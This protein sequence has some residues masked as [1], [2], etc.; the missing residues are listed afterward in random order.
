MTIKSPKGLVI[1]GFAAGILVAGASAIAVASVSSWGAGGSRIAFLV[2]KPTGSVQPSGAAGYRI[3]PDPGFPIQSPGL[4]RPEPTATP[5]PAYKGPPWA[6]FLGQSSTDPRIHVVS[7]VGLEGLALA[8]GSGADR[9]QLPKPATQLPLVSTS[10]TRAYYLDG[11]SDLRYLM[12][13]GKSGLARHIPGTAT[14]RAV[15]AV[16]PDDQQIAVST[17]DYGTEPPALRFFIEGMDGSHHLDLFSSRTE[18]LWPIGWHAG[19]VVMAAGEA[20]P[21]TNNHVGDGYQYCDQTLGPCTSDNPY[22]ATHGYRLIDARNGAQVGTMASGVCTAIGLMTPS[23]TLC[24]EG[25]PPGGLITPTSVCRDELTFCLRQVDWSGAITDWTTE[26]VT[27][28][29]VLAGDGTGVAACCNVNAINLYPPRRI[30][31]TARQVGPAAWPL[32]FLDRS[33]L[34]YRSFGA[35]YAHMRDLD[36]GHDVTI[37]A[38]GVPVAN[39]PGAF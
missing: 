18:Y 11:N 22:S 5:G 33:T 3:V 10:S 7:I 38:P 16:S 20:Y 19:N 23:G 34:V 30:G 26:A 12:P 14:V 8:S 36:S 31:G 29:G 37:N 21:K 28:T 13:D 25:S 4:L 1:A 27:W 32:A 24:R 9:S 6:V 17:I 35:T 15:F 2:H 39:L